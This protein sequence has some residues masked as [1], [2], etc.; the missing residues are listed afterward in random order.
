MTE[1]VD[2]RAVVVGWGRGLWEEISWGRVD[3]G[4]VE[5]TCVKVLVVGSV[6]CSVLLLEFVG[7]DDIWIA[8]KKHIW[9]N[10]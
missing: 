7:L 1:G 2:V 10:T 5:M 3:E 4:R 9:T 6:G 8:C